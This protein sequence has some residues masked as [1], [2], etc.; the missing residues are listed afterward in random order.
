MER[1]ESIKHTDSSVGELSVTDAP[2]QVHL[3]IALH[4]DIV[5]W[6]LCDT[7]GSSREMCRVQLSGFL[8]YLQHTEAAIQC[9]RDFPIPLSPLVLCSRCYTGNRSSVQPA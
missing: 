7:A 3:A 2:I 1:R 9:I 6:A 4:G 8:L 5:S